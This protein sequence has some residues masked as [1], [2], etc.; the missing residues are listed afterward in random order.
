MRTQMLFFFFL[1]P[2]LKHLTCDRYS[3]IFLSY[4]LHVGQLLVKLFRGKRMVLSLILRC[5][6]EA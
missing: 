6:K 4:I 2:L 1:L 3:Y 5:V